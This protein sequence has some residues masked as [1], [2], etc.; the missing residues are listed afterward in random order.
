MEGADDGAQCIDWM[1]AVDVDDDDDDDDVDDVQPVLGTTCDHV[2]R[3]MRARGTSSPI[4]DTFIVAVTSYLPR[5][6]DVAPTPLL[7]SRTYQMVSNHTESQID[8][9]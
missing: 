6:D 7:P 4:Q 5:L 9:I 2:I 3:D 1:D 8:I